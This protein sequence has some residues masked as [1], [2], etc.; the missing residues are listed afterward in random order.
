M[1]MQPSSNTSWKNAA[2]EDAF[3]AV[4]SE[5]G[6]R[7]GGPKAWDNESFLAKGR[8]YVELTRPGWEGATGPVL[9]VGCGAGRVTTA[10]ASVFPKI[11]A[12]DVSPAMLERARTLCT[13]PNV[14]FVEGDGV[15]LPGSG[16][17]LVFSTQVIQHISTDALPGVFAEIGRVLAPGGR[18]VLH[19]PEPNLQATIDSWRHLVPLRKLATNVARPFLKLNYSRWPWIETDYNLYTH[20]QVARFASSGGLVIERSFLF[21]AGSRATRTYVLVHG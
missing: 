13:A 6:R 3:H 10:L 4:A 20:D 8:E 5:K 12:V 9:E 16:Y 21:R 17:G 7:K 18:A 19:I 1:V 15:T 14:E 11:V 2:Q